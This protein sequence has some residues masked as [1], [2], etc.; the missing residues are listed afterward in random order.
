MN[1]NELVKEFRQIRKEYAW[2]PD[3]MNDEEPRIARLKEIIEKKLS[4][5]DR[6]ILLLYV[7]C[8]SY[9]KLGKKLGLSQMTCWKEVARIK[10]IVLDEYSKV[11]K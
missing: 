1:E 8:Q 2:N 6:T 5:A 7:D 3:I 11:K 9:R 4:Q 10:Q